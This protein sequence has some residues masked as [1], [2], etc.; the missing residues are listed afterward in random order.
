MKS[1]ILILTLLLTISIKSYSAEVVIIKADPIQSGD[2]QEVVAPKDR[3][4][5]KAKKLGYSAPYEA[6][7]VGDTGIVILTVP[8]LQT[9]YERI[10]TILQSSNK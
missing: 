2:T 9:E 7:V 6:L 5:L 3:I 8:I 1:T 10:K 4:I